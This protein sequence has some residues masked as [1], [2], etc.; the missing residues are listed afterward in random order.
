MFIALQQ[1]LGVCG[2]PPWSNGTHWSVVEWMSDV[3]HRGIACRMMCLLP[4]LSLVLHVGRGEAYRNSTPKTEEQENGGSSY[5]W[6]PTYQLCLVG[7][8]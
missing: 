1:G 2:E 8:C 7:T 3:L 4:A 5:M 6:Q